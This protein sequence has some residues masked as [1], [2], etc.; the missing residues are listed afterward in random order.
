MS[1]VQMYTFHLP[2]TADKNTCSVVPFVLARDTEADLVANT[3]AVEPGDKFLMAHYSQC[4]QYCR[5]YIPYYIL[6]HINGLVDAITK[7]NPTRDI[8]RGSSSYGRPTVSDHSSH[9]V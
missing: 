4:S 9:D 6:Y 3:S 5:H 8:R 7:R 2:G 1:S